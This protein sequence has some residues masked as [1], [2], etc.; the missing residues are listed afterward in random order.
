MHAG[1]KPGTLEATV[2][3]PSDHAAKK[4]W[5]VARVPS[6]HIQKVTLDGQPWTQLDAAREAI[7]LPSRAGT[8]RLEIEYR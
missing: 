4:N 6:G 5:L 8:M 2:E 1:S 7:E 3:L